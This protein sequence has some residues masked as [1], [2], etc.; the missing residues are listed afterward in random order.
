MTPAR[1]LRAHARRTPHA[2]PY[3]ALPGAPLAA[4]AALSYEALDRRARA[5]AARLG[6]LVAPGSTVLLAYRPGADLAG[7]FYGC[8]YAGMVAVPCPLPNGT[9]RR[10]DLEPAVDRAEP[11]VVLTAADGWTPLPVD[12]RRVRVVEADGLRVGDR[13]VSELAGDWRPLGVPSIVG[14]Y[15][16]FVPGSPGDRRG[17]RLEPVLSHG[18][19]THVLGEL[20]RAVRLGAD[21]RELG[22]IASVQGLEDPVWRL[23]LPVQEGRVV[24]ETGGPPRSW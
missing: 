9:V 24:W 23:L 21:E 3:D 15:R 12:Q 18:D 5:V 20:R 8:L 1:A 16:Q 22:W 6:A 11:A 4:T 17:G 19:L 2:V 13:P 14:A 7:A 10:D